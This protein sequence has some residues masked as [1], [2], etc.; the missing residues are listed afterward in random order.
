MFA[1]CLCLQKNFLVR[2]TNKNFLKE[3]AQVKASLP[4]KI[5][6]LSNSTSN[7]VYVVKHL[8]N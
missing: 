2:P 6:D 7:W 4:L 5:Y 3:F 8:Y 1:S